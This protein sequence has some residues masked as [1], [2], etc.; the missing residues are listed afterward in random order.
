MMILVAIG[1]VGFSLA[2]LI[3]GIRLCLLARRTRQLPELLLGVSFLSG[4]FLA[5]TLGWVLYTPLRPSE[6]YLGML[7]FL[8]RVAV[9]LAGILL[10]LMAWRVFR[11]HAAWARIFVA[12]VSAALLSYV[13]VSVRS[14]RLPNAERM[15]NPMY[16]VQTLGMMAPYFWLTLES[17]V[18]QSRMR[19]RWRIGLPADLVVAERM[20]F[21]AV[22]IGT[23]ALMFVTLEAVRVV[24]VI[25]GKPIFP[26]LMISTLG[27]A[28][29]IALTLAFFL[30]ESYR[31]RI[32][33]RAAAGP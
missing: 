6:P 30:P 12:V 9:A 32:E 17:W 24:A 27:I 2:S 22:G 28:C 11:P 8:L 29:T 20:G 15:L 14:G 13:F 1:N 23:Q 33:Q 18:Y 19:R 10:L 16:W 4:G 3:L 25:T 31:R 5:S 21:W 26:A 7:F